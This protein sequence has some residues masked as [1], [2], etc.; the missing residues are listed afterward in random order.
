MSEEK[1]NT[2]RTRKGK[3]GDRKLK[4]I[5]RDEI[6]FKYSLNG[7]NLSLSPASLREMIRSSK[8][9]TSVIKGGRCSWTSEHGN[10]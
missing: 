4:E 6:G 5:E 10:L 7:V 1:K 3:D 8:G 9:N 2:E